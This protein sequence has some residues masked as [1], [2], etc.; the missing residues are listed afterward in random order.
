MANSSASTRSNA[1][2]NTLA[3]ACPNADANTTT[4]LRSNGR[5]DAHADVD[6]NTTPIMDS[7]VTSAHIPTDNVADT[8]ANGIANASCHAS[9]NFGTNESADGAAY[10][11]TAWGHSRSDGDADGKPDR[12]TDFEPHFISNG[13]AD[14][15]TLGKANGSA[16]TRAQCRSYK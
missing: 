1:V 15:R 11:I 12:R 5:T 14:I 4:N 6:A 10:S 3:Y 9:T 8:I 2:A 16:N 13:K 7:D